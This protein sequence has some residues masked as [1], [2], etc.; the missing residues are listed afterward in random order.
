MP[1]KYRDGDLSQLVA[2]GANNGEFVPYIGFLAVATRTHESVRSA[3]EN[4][5]RVLERI[6]LSAGTPPRRERGKTSRALLRS[7]STS[8]EDPKVFKFLSNSHARA[9]TGSDILLPSGPCLLP[10][11]SSFDRRVREQPPQL[12]SKIRAVAAM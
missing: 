11:S 2:R 7:E 9:A 5:S 8:R 1:P 12:R 3:N 4:R 10:F 6:L